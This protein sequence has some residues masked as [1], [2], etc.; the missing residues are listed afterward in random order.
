MGSMPRPFVVVHSG[1]TQ[2]IERGFFA[3]SSFN[4]TRLSG[5]AGAAR[6]CEKASRMARKSVMRS[7]FRVLGYERVK[8]GQNIPAR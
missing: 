7:T 8:M 6:G 5:F 1:K 4:V 3:W 2:I